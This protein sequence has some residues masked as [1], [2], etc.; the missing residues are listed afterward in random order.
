MDSGRQAALTSKPGR[1]AFILRMH[2]QGII[3]KYRG[4]LRSIVRPT[5][6]I[7]FW[8]GLIFFAA[9]FLKDGLVFDRKM[10]QATLILESV[11][12]PFLLMIIGFCTLTYKITIFRDGISSY[13]P[14]GTYKRDFLKYSEMTN[15]E[16]RSVFGYRYYFIHSD[17][18]SET[19]WIPFHVKDKKGFIDALV[20]ILSREHMIVKEM[21]KSTA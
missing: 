1:C 3:S 14:W 18:G 16:I 13:D 21:A 12:I 20:S 9:I 17:D 7:S 6:N 8:A 11:M 2:M 5:F 4:E 10:L 15:I 19:L